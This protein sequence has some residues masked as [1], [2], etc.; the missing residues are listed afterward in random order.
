MRS[1]STT[2]SIADL[3]TGTAVIPI[4]KVVVCGGSGIDIA[5][6]LHAGI[7]SRRAA[8]HAGHGHGST[9]SDTYY[10]I[11]Q[12]LVGRED[13]VV[14]DATSVIEL[15]D[16]SLGVFWV[17]A[18]VASGSASEYVAAVVAV[19]PRENEPFERLGMVL[20]KGNPLVACVN[21]ALAS[22]REAGTLA[23]LESEWLHEG[24]TIPILTR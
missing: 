20:Q 23:E 11:E 24:G 14:V 13:S 6:A 18:S 7:G 3:D 15:S 4:F 12:M 19:L 8:S 21:E 5:A 1:A 16:A 2:K 17:T 9:V 10:D 22:L